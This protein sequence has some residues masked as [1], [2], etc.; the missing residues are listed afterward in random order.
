MCHML[1]MDGA[2][3]RRRREALGLTQTQLAR[4]FGVGLRTVQE[5]EKGV[6]PIRPVI[7]MALET[8]EKP[9]PK[10]QR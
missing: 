1:V 4:A 7:E 8:L 5:W 2:E 9:G 6:R 10:R 3:L